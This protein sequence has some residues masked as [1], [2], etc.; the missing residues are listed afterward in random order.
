MESELDPLI[1]EIKIEKFIDLNRTDEYIPSAGFRVSSNGSLIN[2][3]L[4]YSSVNI[5]DLNG[6]IQMDELIPP[7]EPKILSIKTEN[8][9]KLVDDYFNNDSNLDDGATNILED[10]N[11]AEANEGTILK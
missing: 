7:K 4:I 1:D 5:K 6:L 9:D 10:S 8:I 2:E 11:D 3:N